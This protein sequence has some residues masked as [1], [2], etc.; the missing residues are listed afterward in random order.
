MASLLLSPFPTC[1]LR[2]DCLHRSELERLGQPRA[3]QFYS[4]RS[5]AHPVWQLSA[6]VSPMVDFRLQPCVRYGDPSHAPCLPIG[7]ARWA[8][9][10]CRQGSLTT[11]LI[12]VGPTEGASP[13]RERAMVALA[14][15]QNVYYKDFT[16]LPLKQSGDHESRGRR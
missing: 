11:I 1:L 16:S 4:Q 10:G 8:H 13:R 2:S 14:A 5:T 12:D 7:L 3:A 9:V 15:P 6:H